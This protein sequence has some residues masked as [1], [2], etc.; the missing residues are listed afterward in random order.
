MITILVVD[1]SPLERSLVKS[2]LNRNP[3]YQVDL[4]ENG[5]DALEKIRVAQPDLVVTDLLMPEVDG[6]Q[7]VRRMRTDYPDIPV[8]LMTACGDEATAIDSLEA[9]AASYVPKAKQAER[10]LGTVDRVI[11][12]REVQ[13]N[14][15][16]LGRCLLE[17]H[18]RY[19]LENDL[20]LVQALVNEVQ[21]VMA[22]QCFGD[23]VERIR[24]GEALEEALQNA[25]YHGNLEI[26]EHELAQV[27]S[28]LDD[29]LLHRLIEQRCAEPRIGERRI[30][31]VVHLTPVEARFVIRDQGRGFSTKLMNSRQAGRFEAGSCRGLTLIESI[32]DCVSYNEHGNEMTM[33][34]QLARSAPG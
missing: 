28:E 11:A 27:R 30:L 1:D 25:L 20:A 8:I 17:Y 22:D 13:R 33:R 19:W 4:A 23:T 3:N 5:R 14:R 31:A 16:R 21:R 15:Q 2:L 6:L 34:K 29:S 26:N 12:H 7:L 18:C 10:L 32:M 24:I 9:G